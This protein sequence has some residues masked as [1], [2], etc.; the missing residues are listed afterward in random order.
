MKKINEAEW[1]VDKEGNMKVP[2]T[3]IGTEKIVEQMKRDR[4]LNQIKNVASLPGIVKHALVMPDGHEGYGFPIG[5]VAAFDIENG[6][7]SPGGVGY[8]INC[9]TGNTKI[10]TPYGWY[11]SIKEHNFLSNIELTTNGNTYLFSTTQ[12][13]SVL[14]K[15]GISKVKNFMYREHKGKIYKIKSTGGTITCTGEHPI[16]TTEGKKCAKNI[17]TEQGILTNPIIGVEYKKYKSLEE[18]KRLSII[19]KIFGYLIGDGVVYKSNNKFYAV[20]YGK[21]ED[22]KKMMTDLKS[23]GYASKT[24][25]RLR[26][27]NINGKQFEADNWELHIYSK[28]FINELI[29][30]GMPLGN[31]TKTTTNIPNWIMEGPLWIKRQFLAGYFGA[32]MSKPKSMSKTCLYLPDVTMTKEAKN[33]NNLRFFMLQLSKILEEFEIEV[34]KI[35][36]VEKDSKKIRMRILINGKAENLIKLYSKIG[37]EY[38]KKREFLAKCAILYLR[39]KIKHRKERSELAKWIKK[40]RKQGFK[41]K[42]LKKI[43]K[44]EI[45]NRFIERALYENAGTRIS[46]NFPSFEEFVKKQKGYLRIYGALVAEIDTI[47]EKE[48]KGKVYDFT[49]EKDHNFVANGIIVSNCGVRLVT[50]GLTVEQV[51]P[52]LDELIKKLFNNV[53]SG[54]GAKSKLR[55]DETQLK[56][57]L[58]NGVQWAV[59]NGYGREED[60]EHCEEYGKM[61]GAD[62]S[63]VS[64]NAMKRGKPQ[65]GTLGAGNH[66]LE[67]QKV[68]EIVLPDIAEKFKLKKDEV[69]VM[70]HCGSRGFGHQVCGDYID[71]MLRASEKYKINLPDRELCCAPLKS[72]E[73]Q[74]YLKAMKCAVNYA[75]T[76]RQVIMHWV[77]ETFDEVFGNKTSENMH[78]VYDVAHNI[79]KIEE[80]E[81][82]GKTMKVCVHRKGATRAFAKGRKELPKTYIDIG[83]PVLIPGSMGT[84]SYVLVGK[85][86]GMQVSFGST[87]HGAGRVMSRSEAIRSFTFD[88]VKKEMENKGI[89]LLA[90]DKTVAQE[91]ASGAYKDVDEVVKSVALSGISDIVVKLK[92]IGVVKG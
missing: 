67:I 60:I 82:D 34:S 85:E 32:E 8:D 88:Q 18:D 90:A 75:F 10:P 5:G 6:I 40:K 79:A 27:H 51:T 53:P 78:L 80:H 62:P 23:I 31:K 39:K 26:T 83:Q 66:F 73:A 59:K 52:K 30:L 16:Y 35:T 47:K 37:F 56:N 3:I 72:E 54:V 43:L 33:E 61:E 11:M 89:K 69:V 7:I 74:N 36:T 28:E 48:Y 86:K 77:R 91:E 24:Y 29:G 76:N 68:D 57:A 58:I 63:A 41:S 46:L 19:T 21:E 1:Q 15:Q 22:L 50:T 92:P 71:I 84:A 44:G 55:V 9:L 70:I 20:A 38:N 64:K 4:T 13:Y 49:I 87:C 45:N 81:V 17:N 25:H 14:S 42:E 65:F 12:T 2:I